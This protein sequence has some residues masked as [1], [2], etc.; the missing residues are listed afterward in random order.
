MDQT[1]STPGEMPNHWDI[2]AICRGEHGDPFSLLGLHGAGQRQ[3]VRA[4]MPLAQAV[5][6]IDAASGQTMCALHCIDIRGLFAA[7][8]PRRAKPFAYR[9]S[10]RWGDECHL[11]DDPYRFPPHPD[12]R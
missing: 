12:R 10:V 5:D 6:L 3:V 2:E 11:L 4:W 8:V 1:D 9:L 7:T